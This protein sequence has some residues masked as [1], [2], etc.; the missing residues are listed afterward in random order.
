MIKIGSYDKNSLVRSGIIG[1]ILKFSKPREVLIY[2]FLDYLYLY[3]QPS[4]KDDPLVFMFWEGDRCI[5]SSFNDL[6]YTKKYGLIKENFTP[7]PHR[8]LLS[9]SGFYLSIHKVNSQKLKQFEK[10]KNAK[11]NRDNLAELQNELLPVDKEKTESLEILF[12][13][14][15]FKLFFIERGTLNSLLSAIQSEIKDPYMSKLVDDYEKQIDED[16]DIK[17]VNKCTDGLRVILDEC[18]QDIQDFLSINSE[19]KPELGNI[20]CVIRM[21]CYKNLRYTIFP[22]TA[23]ILLSKN[24]ANILQDWME[25]KCNK[26]RKN[27]KVK[28]G[29]NIV[30]VLEAPLSKNARAIADLV[31]CSGIVEFGREPS[32][33]VWD[34]YKENFEMDKSRQQVERCIYPSG[35]IYYVP[36]HVGG[37]PWLALFTFSSGQDR[38]LYNYTFYRDIISVVATKL[39]LKALDQYI[40][41]IGNIFIE[42]LN[43][44]SKLVSEFIEETNKKLKWLARIY[45]FP[46]IRIEENKK[47]K[48]I[49]VLYYRNLPIIAKEN[50]FF[51]KPQVNYG[52]FKEEVLLEKVVDYINKEV[53]HVLEIHNLSVS[54]HSAIFSHA[55]PT[56]I[57]KIK[58]DVINKRYE[59]VLEKLDFLSNF[60]NLAMAAIDSR[61]RNRLNFSSKK[62]E[63]FK[64]FLQET[65]IEKTIERVADYIEVK[66]KITFFWN[67]EKCGNVIYT[68]EYLFSVIYEVIL[69]AVKYSIEKGNI[70][71]SLS[72]KNNDKVFLIVSNYSRFDYE[73]TKRI[74]K[75]ILEGTDD[76]L[77]TEF[78]KLCARA[79]NYDQPKWRCEKINNGK[80]TKIITEIQIAKMEEIK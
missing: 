29:A 43:E 53:S 58:G 39:R 22:Y 74:I 72:L 16:L 18:W 37:H 80:Y 45:P 12:E 69:N 23:K 50:P 10:K 20:F 25:H 40:L 49:D 14:S 15:Q 5:F 34:T 21:A 73:K 11:S 28:N 75:A 7:P 76:Y 38:W 51:G 32:D 33:K 42:K 60:C 61:R 30:D 47:A 19:D 17:F 27:C 8:M 6:Y 56:Y 3:F 35:Y 52:A 79:C 59:K 55:M 24:Q 46:L 70:E 41:Q 66:P 48:K 36:I 9:D 2:P 71:I 65:I 13:D 57:N 78:L 68:E 62:L 44:P 1:S 63:E 31:F 77:G 67:I 4:K 64:F 26:C 54:R